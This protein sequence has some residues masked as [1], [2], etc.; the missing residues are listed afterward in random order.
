[1]LEVVH[2]SKIFVTNYKTTQNHN[3][4]DRIQHLHYCDNLKL[5]SVA[6]LL[7]WSICTDKNI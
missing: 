4:E 3:L 5:Q 2:S 6:L 1:M 7:S